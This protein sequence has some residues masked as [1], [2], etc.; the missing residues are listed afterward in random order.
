[1]KKVTHFFLKRSVK[2]PFLSYL[3]KKVVK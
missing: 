1:M 3:N 2:E